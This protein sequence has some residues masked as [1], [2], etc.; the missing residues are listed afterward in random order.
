MK[1]RDPKKPIS[2]EGLRTT[3][4]KERPSLVKR[5]DLGRVH[6]PGGRFSEFLESLPNI[7]GA[8]DLVRAKDAIVDAHL[9]GREVILGMG[10]HPIKVGLSPVIIDL[11]ERRVITVVA[12]NGAGIIHYFELAY[13]GAT[14]EEVSAT[15]DAGEFGTAKETA[16]FLNHAVKQGYREGLGLGES[17]GRAVTDGS[18]EYGDLSIL[19]AGARLGIPVTV[20]VALGTDVIHIHPSF[21]PDAVG[22]ASHLDFRIFA[23]AVS[24][25][26]GG[27]FIN[28]GSA[29]IMP[30][31]FLKAV[32]LVR[33]LGHK[34]ARFTALN[35]DFALHYRPLTNV[36]G[37]PVASGGTGISLVGHH[38]INF[39][40]LAAAVIEAIPGERGDE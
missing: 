11:M 10:A 21:D 14:S 15:L 37:R 5:E 1:E 22:G 16:Q 38:E 24:R 35:M 8:E 20:H 34:I 17:V 29:V 36:V 3:S 19:A 32:T 31:V 28:L 6:R 30:E 23:H 12:M 18:L 25:L 2:L 4:L 26:E 39:P 9:R 7:L 33:N 13:M 40:L 27:V